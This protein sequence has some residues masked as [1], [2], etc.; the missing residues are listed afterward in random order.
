[1]PPTDESKKLT[2]KTTETNRGRHARHANSVSQSIPQECY[3]LNNSAGRNIGDISA[4][5]VA[6][7]PFRM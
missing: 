2:T 6:T 5:A 7:P 3:D 1:M 4:Q